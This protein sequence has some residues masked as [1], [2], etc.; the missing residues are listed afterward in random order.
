VVDIPL[1]D[2]S[3]EHVNRFLSLSPGEEPVLLRRHM[4]EVVLEL[5]GR[6]SR[7]PA[8]Y[9]KGVGGAGKSI[10]LRFCAQWAAASG[11][12]VLELDAS[13]TRPK[14]L[15]S[16]LSELVPELSATYAPL[17][18]DATDEEFDQQATRWFGDLF[19]RGKSSPLYR[20]GRKVLLV[21]D[22]WN[23]F[24]TAPARACATYLRCFSD[25]KQHVRSIGGWVVAAVSSS[26]EPISASSAPLPTSTV[27]STAA[28]STSSSPPVPA[29]STNPSPVGL[30]C[31]RDADAVDLA[32]A[33]PI[34][35]HDE[36]LAYLHFHRQQGLLPPNIHDRRI[37]DLSGMVPRIMSYFTVEKLR[38]SMIAA[39][40]PCDPAAWTATAIE[41]QHQKKALE[42]YRGSVRS[43]LRD[44][45][46]RNCGVVWHFFRSRPIDSLDARWEASGMFRQSVDPETGQQRWNVVCS[47]ALD[48]IIAETQSQRDTL[49]RIMAA[50]PT[51]RGRA[52]ELAFASMFIG[53]S[54]PTVPHCIDIPN[55]DLQGKL[56]D[57]KCPTLRIS[58][59]KWVFQ[60][61]NLEVP[62]FE[63]GTFVVCAP[64]I[65]IVD[66]VVH[67]TRGQ[68]FFIQLS[69]S[70]YPRQA[71]YP[72][73]FE[74]KAR[75]NNQSVA[76]FFLSLLPQTRG[77]PRSTRLP[78]DALY[79]YITTR[80]LQ[81]GGGADSIPEC[82]QPTV[83]VPVEVLR[84]LA[85]ER[86]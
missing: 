60:A 76:Q 80:S 44:Q 9:V 42:Y 39:S 15:H 64:G 17:P 68:V 45:S 47:A 61:E 58:A 51:I 74:P 18:S 38:D 35:E 77:R 66:F 34:F 56:H 50:D 82:H 25:L 71:K 13:H 5:L 28:T 14:A 27:D 21:I 11:W 33:V 57:P 43:L 79:V 63:V 75:L 67:S 8:R 55:I 46:A 30:P 19:A 59:S 23:A 85:F 26:F 84:E 22:Q 16:A 65:E 73:L 69:V 62:S 32:Y 37:C 2:I 24:V 6:P 54:D 78:V 48:A 31:F 40:Q 4:I 10:L 3:F 81:E 12:V 20:E 53:R 70:P 29:G 83:F 72:D 1:R 7:T 41:A 36:G 49:L 52:F 86:C